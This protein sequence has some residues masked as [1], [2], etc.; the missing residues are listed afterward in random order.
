MKYIDEF[1]DA[2]LV[3]ETVKKINNVVVGRPLTFMEVCGGHTMAIRK[4]GIPALLPEKI[5]LIS[6]PGCPVCVTGKGFIDSVISYS[7]HKNIIIATYGDLL[8]VPGS[9]SSLAE[10]KAKGADIRIIYSPIESIAIAKNNPDKRVIFPGIGFETT[11]PAT[12]VTIIKANELEITN[13]LVLSAHKVMPPAMEALIDEGVNIDGYI[14]PGHVSTITGTGIYDFIPQKYNIPVVVSGFEPLDLLQ[15]I[16]LLLLQ[17]ENSKAKVEIQYRRAVKPEGN[18]KAQRLL[19]KVFKPGDASWRGIGIIPDS[20]LV[21]K[22]EYSRFDAARMIPIDLPPE[23][24]SV[25]CICGEILKGL[26]DPSLCK[27]FRKGCTPESPVGAC[28]VSMEGACNIYY[29]Y[30]TYG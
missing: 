7:K 4:N 17:I 27:L 8:R 24:E 13:L 5:K 30:N 2:K 9:F 16:L 20:G 14:A 6:G 11:A 10:E 21:L 18:K 1:R 15:S 3:R 29:R 25:G 12:A 26:G 23:K 22:D 19:D 28:M